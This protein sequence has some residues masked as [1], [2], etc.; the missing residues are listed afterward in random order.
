MKKEYK[1]KA[2]GLRKTLLEGN[3]DLIRKAIADLKKEN[4]TEFEEELLKGIRYEN[5]EEYTGY[6]SWNLVPNDFFSLSDTDEQFP[7][8]SGNLWFGLISLV[9]SSQCRTAIE[10]RKNI[11][12]LNF[13]GLNLPELPAEIE[14]FTE[15]TELVLNNCLQSAFFSPD[16]PLP[17]TSFP[18]ELGNLKKLKILDLSQNTG[19]GPPKEIS[20]LQNLEKLML[21]S[22]QLS[23][24]PEE[25]CALKKLKILTLDN[26]AFTSLP[27]SIGNL[28]ELKEL[29]LCY[30]RLAELPAGIGKLKSLEILDVSGNP[31][32]SLP[33]E[34]KSLDGL[35]KLS[36]MNH[37]LT[38]FPAFLKEMENLSDLKSS[39]TP[40]IAGDNIAEILQK[41]FARESMSAD[42]RIKV[43]CLG[44]AYP[45]AAAV[46][47][48]R[49]ICS[50]A[51]KIFLFDSDSMNQLWSEDVSNIILLSYSP[52]GSFFICISE[53]G[54]IRRYNVSD[55]HAECA[56]EKES[57]AMPVS[58]CISPDS[59]TFAVCHQD[60]AG[61]VRIRKC[62]DGTVKKKFG[63]TD[64]EGAYEGYGY[65]GLSFSADGKKI[66]ACDQDWGRVRVWN[67]ETGKALKAVSEEGV[68]FYSA[69]CTA[70][71]RYLITG[72]VETTGA[73]WN[74]E[75]GI[76]IMELDDHMGISRI[77]SAHPTDGKLIGTATFHILNVWNLKSGQKI[78]EF[79]LVSDFYS[80]SSLSFSEN[81]FL[82]AL[83]SYGG[84]EEQKIGSSYIALAFFSGESE[85]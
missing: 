44:N 29:T 47:K 61:Y 67:A 63:N 35:K 38:S 4:I 48:N 20:R 56:W 71:G 30:S 53:S 52:D 14:N 40:W 18:A 85:I 46:W 23:R 77:V 1:K 72:A 19:F 27:E 10:L 12:S 58:I 43:L 28:T 26:N 76:K 2:D 51:E 65:S 69:D 16:E 36:L 25:I 84:Y 33:E 78:S 64:G 41:N 39:F 22:S 3:I 75:K 83:I 9:G 59:E 17:E 70:D 62:A 42:P 79:S 82:C 81:G 54:S 7:E 37:R 45:K 68:Q 31:L 57:E 24:F 49:I 73:V 21:S 74:S 11:K 13:F 6:E 66:Y 5:A 60:M 15:L 34:M 55:H 8:S 50:T 80:V 32:Q